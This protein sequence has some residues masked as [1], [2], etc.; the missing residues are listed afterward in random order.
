MFLEINFP[1]KPAVLL[2]ERVDLVRDFSFVKNIAAFFA[3]QSQSASERR[4]F[5]NV[6]LGRRAAFAIQRV[7]FKKTSGQTFVKPRT[8]APVIRDQLGYG[9][10]FVGI[11]S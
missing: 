4:V 2:H 7:G 6:A 9:K 8:E 11:T 1:Q 3:D 10:S 5:E